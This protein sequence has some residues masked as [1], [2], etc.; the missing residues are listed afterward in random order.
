MK[1][2]NQDEPIHS[3]PAGLALH[4][5]DLMTRWDIPAETFLA[6]LQI[7]EAE[8]ITPHA[9]L[10]VPLYVRLVERA[11]ELTGEPGLGFLMG[12]QMRVSAYGYLGFAAMSA[13]TVREAIDCAIQFAPL[14]QSAIH[15]R[16]H[17]EDRRASLIFDEAA[18]F[19]SARDAII[20]ACLAGLWRIASTITGRDLNGVAELAF[21]E[22]AYHARFAHLVPETVY[23]QRMHRIVLKEEALDVPLIMADPAALRL[24]RIQ[25]EAAIDSLGPTRVL[26]DRVRRLVWKP[27][28]GFRSL[29]EVAEVVA[30]S[31][32][33]LKRKLALQGASFSA[34]CEEERRQRALILLRSP[35][36][37]IE[38]VADRLGYWN[39]QNFTR[40]F[41]RWTARTPAA[42]RRDSNGA[43][44]PIQGPHSST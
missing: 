22:P 38:E 2:M 16:L 35:E 4:L 12:L 32:R 27:Q 18:D 26:A 5:V 13:G 14:A 3:V 29:E 33:T 8:L 40:A 11:R 15:L 23:G 39:V 9:R 36:L 21:P 28:G 43:H 7:D 20:I 17:V 31:S 19:G 10:P 24:A 34:L 44:S 42:F 25:C 37:S 41:R 1:T 6:P 30:M